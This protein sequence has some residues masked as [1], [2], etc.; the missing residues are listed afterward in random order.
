M[1]NV[2]IEE[3][4]YDHDFVDK[5]CYGFEELA[6]AATEWTPEKAA[7]VCWVDADKIVAA[8][9][10]YAKAKPA[11]IQWGLK[12]DQTT[13][14]TSTANAVNSLWALTGNVDNPGG[15]I[16]IR[17]AFDQNLSYGYGYQ[18][19]TPEMQGKKLGAEFPC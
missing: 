9:R 4:L 1:I 19:L 2:M 16:V 10:M 5:W 18:L 11:A 13:N 12:I 7:E 17:N 15:N 6:E 14:A 3:D 8:A